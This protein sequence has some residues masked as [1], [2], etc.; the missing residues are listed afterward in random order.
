[1][2]RNKIRDSILWGLQKLQQNFGFDGK[3]KD[4]VQKRIDNIE[5]VTDFAIS[6]RRAPTDYEIQEY[7]ALM[8]NK[9]GK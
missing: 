4:K 2:S 3:Q 1:M 9:N 7:L 6:H 8:K 5:F